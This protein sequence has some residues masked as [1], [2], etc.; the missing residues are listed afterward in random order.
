MQSLEGRISTQSSHLSATH[1]LDDATLCLGRKR[2]MSETVFEGGC[3]CGAVR[4]RATARPLRCMICHC[5]DCRKHSGAPCLSFVHFSVKAF[6]WQ[7]VEPKRYRSSR[8]AERGF[9]P[10][11]GSTLSMH[12]E[13]LGDRVQVTLGS[14]DTPEMVDVDDHVWTGSRIPWFEIKDDHPRFLR[15]STAVASNADDE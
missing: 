3:L 12:E 14:L 8:Y 2:V 6:T 5:A 9:C 13:V 4:Y 10:E 15:S 11:C 7:G 1:P